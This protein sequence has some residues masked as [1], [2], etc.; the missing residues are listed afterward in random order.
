MASIRKLPNGKWQARIR[1]TPN[2]RQYSK[3]TR[4][5]VDA[6]RWLSEQTAAIV[7]GQFVDPR[8]GD[9]TLREYAED[10][11]QRQVHRPSTERHVEMMLRRHVYPTLGDNRLST[12]TPDDVQ[13]WVRRLELAPATVHVVHAMLSQVFKS[14]CRP[15]RRLA[16]NPC[17]DTRLPEVHRAEAEPLTADQV[18]ALTAAM[19]DLGAIV[20]LAAGTG[21]RQGECVGL[22]LDRVN[23]L[24][25]TVKVDRQLVT[26]PGRDPYLAPPKSSA[27]IRTIPLPQFVVEALSVV[28]QDLDEGF[29][30]TYLGKPISRSVFG[31]MW[32]PA[33]AEAGLPTGTGFHRLRHTYASALIEAGLSVKVVQSRLG[34]KSA[35][36]TL[37][38]YGH[39]FGDGED[40]TRD[41][42]DSVFGSTEERLR[43]G[44]GGGTSLRRSD[45]L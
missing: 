30:F 20:T 24:R 11:R 6:Q 10:W 34:H 18:E 39:M 21:L 1:L 42:L 3:T 33:V 28:A 37:D 23:F 26:V 9:I 19:G 36:T 15:P 16:N 44:K 17:A 2:G 22:T 35:T 45:T 27:S 7:V 13:L 38:V 12:V 5:K 40:R 25:R 32:R 4:R 31:H 8:A 14:A 43:N 41:A 29:L